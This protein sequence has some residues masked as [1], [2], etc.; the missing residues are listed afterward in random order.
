MSWLTTRGIEACYRWPISG[1][2]AY[3]AT[4]DRGLRD[5]CP[6]TS[7]EVRFKP[8]N[9]TLFFAILAD[10]DDVVAFG[11]VGPGTVRH[12]GPTG[13]VDSHSA[14]TSLRWRTKPLSEPCPGTEAEGVRT[15]RGIE[16]QNDQTTVTSGLLQ[17]A[18]S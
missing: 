4:D 13:D 6:R 12:G 7:I 3:E 16:R 11:P 8:T 9:S 10:L 1:R 15:P 17:S 5:H 14:A 18:C 2:A